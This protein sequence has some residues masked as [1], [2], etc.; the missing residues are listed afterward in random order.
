MGF[1]VNCTWQ[2]QKQIFTRKMENFFAY[3]ERYI[4][5][6]DLFSIDIKQFTDEFI[7]FRE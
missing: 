2:T 3:K 5:K 4:L 7:R 1:D 6:I